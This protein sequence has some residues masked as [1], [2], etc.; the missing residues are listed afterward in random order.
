MVHS[1]TQTS[2]LNIR[3]FNT[4]IV[5]LCVTTRP[6]E[7]YRPTVPWNIPR[8]FS[9][10]VR[11][12]MYNVSSMQDIRKE[13][14]LSHLFIHP[15]PP[16]PG[17]A[18]SAFEIFLPSQNDNDN[19]DHV[20]AWRPDSPSQQA[21]IGLAKQ[22]GDCADC[23]GNFEKG[24][25]RDLYC[26]NSGQGQCRYASLGGPLD[27]IVDGHHTRNLDMCGRECTTGTF[28]GQFSRLLAAA[29]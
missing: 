12:C 19:D 20:G 29:L 5:V 24:I 23:R 8:I 10:M 1:L 11:T 6:F 22:I 9:L 21:V 14:T 27:R 26:H 15:P 18:N 28:C 25:A 2:S 7:S 4:L 16:V 3:A 17:C 13:I